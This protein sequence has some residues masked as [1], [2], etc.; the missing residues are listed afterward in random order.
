MFWEPF[1]RRDMRASFMRVAWVLF[2][3]E[4]AAWIVNREEL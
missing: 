2:V 4:M 3:K 1:S